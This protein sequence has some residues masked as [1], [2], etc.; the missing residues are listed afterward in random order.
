[1][2]TYDYFPFEVA[3]WDVP[4]WL[5]EHGG[6]CVPCL[7]VPYRHWDM[8]PLMHLAKGADPTL[9]K[10][11][12]GTDLQARISAVPTSGELELLDAINLMERGDYSG[13][14][15]R[16]TTAIE[17]VL[18]ATMFRLIEAAEGAEAARTYLKK[19]NFP[20][21][22]ERYGTISGRTIDDQLK[23][24]LTETR[25]LRHRIVHEG[26]RIH[27]SDRGRAQRSVDTGRWIFNWIEDNQE[28]RKVRE[29]RIGLRS[30]GRDIASSIFSAKITP[31]GVT[32]EPLP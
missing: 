8:K 5:I 21:R 17:V 1:M 23:A 11:I 28:R 15:R 7:L 12:S 27:F 22:L 30:I 29:H 20:S 10:L 13:A 16:I 14:V 9:Y 24:E 19:A 25:R 2:A 18:E 26:F 3:P 4:R 31:D 32:V 6:E